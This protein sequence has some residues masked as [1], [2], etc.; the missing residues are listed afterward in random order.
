MA[1]PWNQLLDWAQKHPDE[2]L[3]LVFGLAGT[4]L[5]V[6]L[7]DLLFPLCKFILNALGLLAVAMFSGF[8]VFDRFFTL[9]RYLRRLEEKVSRLTNPWLTERQQLK[10]IFVPVSASG[11]SGSG[12]RIE[13]GRLLQEAYRIVLIGD[14]GSGKSTGLRAL[15]R[16]CVLRELLTKQ[17]RTLVPD[18]R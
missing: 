2:T 3:K 6:L 9:P 10:D 4:L 11:A 7:K 5:A 18:T 15:A 12:E 17:G 14:P 8:T 16:R 13:L 1:D